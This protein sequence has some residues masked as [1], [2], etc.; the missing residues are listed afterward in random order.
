MTPR[1]LHPLEYPLA[2]RELDDPPAA[3]HVD[4]D[5]TP[6]RLH[7]AIVGARESCTPIIRLVKRLAAS[8]VRAGGIVISGGADGADAAAHLGA[9]KAGGRTWSVLGCGEPH[10]TSSADDDR[11]TR[12]IASG[13]TIIRPFPHDTMPAR[14]NFLT[15]NRFL[16]ALSQIVVVAQGG[17]PSG[18]L[19]AARHA[20]RLR[21]ELWVVPPLPGPEFV[22]N[23]RLI[24]G[25]A[26]VLRSEAEFAARLKEP[27][28]EGDEKTV[29]DALVGSKH[30]DELVVETGL[31]ASAVSTALLT[32]ALGDVVVEGS[33]GLFRRKTLVTG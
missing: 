20:K 11:F 32:L 29:L 22:A 14:P 3:M 9:I 33:A 1:Y 16:V 8:V 13:G 21:R 25:G 6:A 30:P 24:E 5:L 10:F 31:S 15:R 12:I 27:V 19:S 28:L 23:A 7:V 4:G 17:D 2:L 26:R 18:T